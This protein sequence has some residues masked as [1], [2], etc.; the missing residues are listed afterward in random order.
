MHPQD[1]RILHPAFKPKPQERGQVSHLRGRV[2]A[3]EA[4]RRHREELHLES[5]GTWGISVGEADDAGLRCFDDSALPGRP[6]DH[7]F[8]EFGDDLTAPEVKR[9]A[10]KLAAHAQARGPLYSEPT[11]PE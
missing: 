4:H 10:R 7:A 9:L 3:R 8:V 2:D 1:G 5:V 11:E 6:A